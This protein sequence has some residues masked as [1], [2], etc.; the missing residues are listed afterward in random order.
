MTWRAAMATYL[1]KSLSILLIPDLIVSFSFFGKMFLEHTDVQNL[2]SN[3]N[4]TNIVLLI[5]C[6]AIYMSQNNS[7]F[8]SDMSVQSMAVTNEVWHHFFPQL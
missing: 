3:Y 5:C 4:A 6:S 1:D 8:L 7:M 2:T